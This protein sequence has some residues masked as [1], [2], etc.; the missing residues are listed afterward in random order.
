[1]LKDLR[2]F[3]FEETVERAEVDGYLCHIK[4]VEGAQGGPHLSERNNKQTRRDTGLACS[5]AGTEESRRV[6]ACLTIKFAKQTKAEY[7]PMYSRSVAAMKAM[8]C[9]YPWSGRSIT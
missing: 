7:S 9:T 1:M 2:Q 5:S 8:P 3:F 6:F 4:G